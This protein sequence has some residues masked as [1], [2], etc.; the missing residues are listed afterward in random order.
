MQLPG[1]LVEN[2][3]RRRDW[4]FRPVSG[5]L[6]LAL[7]EVKEEAGSAPQA[8]TQA[9]SLAL[10]RLGGGPA[11]EARVAALCVADRQFLM[12]ELERHLGNEG[13]WFQADCRHCGE[14]FDFRID[15]ADLP[16]QEAGAGYPLAQIDLDGRQIRFRLP[17][18]ADQERLA[19]LPDEKA[20]PWLARQLALDADLPEA[21][22]QDLIAAA[23]AALEAIAPGICLTVQAACPECATVNEVDLNPYRVLARQSDPLLQEVHQIALHYH[24]R[25]ADILDLPRARRQRYL[26]LIDR[27]RGMAE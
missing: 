3:T 6:E 1:G 16:V 21:P 20:G 2:G 22:G 5:A 7:A 18:G 26:Q 24:W 14:C 9:L 12:R 8:V 13:G 17:T 15:Y 25:E 4:A 23:E 11:T 19:D 10:D 27:A